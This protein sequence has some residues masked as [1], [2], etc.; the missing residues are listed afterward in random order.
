MQGASE[1]KAGGFPC[2][3]ANPKYHCGD[4]RY[5]IMG[6]KPGCQWQMIPNGCLLLIACSVG[7]Q[8]PNLY[9]MRKLTPTRSQPLKNIFSRPEIVS[10]PVAL[11]TLELAGYGIAL[12]F[13]SYVF[14]SLDSS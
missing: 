9:C 4:I 8:L 11:L 6:V 5:E 3:T 14:Q 10:I 13:L 7:L 1:L 2:R 12:L